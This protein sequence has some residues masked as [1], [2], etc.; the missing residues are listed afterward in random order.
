[1][2]FRRCQFLSSAGE[3][4]LATAAMVPPRIP[5]VFLI[6]GVCSRPFCSFASFVGRECF[7]IEQYPTGYPATAR[8]L[9]MLRFEQDIPHARI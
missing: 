7:L 8:P 1:M 2:L 5:L 6:D 4:R 3:M 9:A